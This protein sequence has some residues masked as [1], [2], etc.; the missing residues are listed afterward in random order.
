MNNNIDRQV[1]GEKNNKDNN[2]DKKWSDDSL[3]KNLFQVSTIGI[4]LVLLSGLGLY[5]GYNLD[6]WFHSSPWLTFVLFCL[7]IFAGFRNIFKTI[8]KLNEK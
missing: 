8:K 2:K 3:G 4:E 7:G 5:M 6:K 1:L